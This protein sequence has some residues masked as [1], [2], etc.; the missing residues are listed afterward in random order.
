[1]IFQSI[2][3][4]WNLTV[5]YYLSAMQFCR[6]SSDQNFPES[7]NLFLQ[8]SSCETNLQICSFLIC[9]ILEGRFLVEIAMYTKLL[10]INH[11]SVYPQILKK[12][13]SNPRFLPFLPRSPILL[14]SNKASSVQRPAPDASA[15]RE[16][17]WSPRASP[18]TKCHDSRRNKKGVPKIGILEDPKCPPQ[19][20]LE[21][22]TNK[23]CKS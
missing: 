13:P 11:V 16:H 8:K 2:S 6:T 7:T 21:S 5:P 3:P 15:A 18:T 22:F 10:W 20:K 17:R 4:P 12:M 23:W 1:M 19:K 9:S 14:L